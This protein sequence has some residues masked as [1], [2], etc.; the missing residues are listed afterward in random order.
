M[1]ARVVDIL[2]YRTDLDAEVR[3]AAAALAA[4]DL[5]AVPTETVYGIAVKL[6]VAAGQA[7]LAELRG[8]S[9]AGAR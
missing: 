8:G 9:A 7:K 4:G 2:D 5:V 1:P 6:D 3:A